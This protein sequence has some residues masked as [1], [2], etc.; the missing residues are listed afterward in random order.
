M[1][2]SETIQ[3]A[4]VGSITACYK[5]VTVMAV[6]KESGLPAMYSKVGAFYYTELSLLFVLVLN[7]GDV[8]RSVQSAKVANHSLFSGKCLRSRHPPCFSR[9]GIS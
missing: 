9:Q 5:A 1:P 6:I 7:C 4:K 2:H 3:A 8:N